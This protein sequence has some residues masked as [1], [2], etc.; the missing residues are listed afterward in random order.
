MPKII[1]GKIAILAAVVFVFVLVYSGLVHASDDWIE[2][3]A[4]WF[5]YLWITHPP[6]MCPSCG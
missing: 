1:F 5:T 3:V 2:R 6:G 4:E